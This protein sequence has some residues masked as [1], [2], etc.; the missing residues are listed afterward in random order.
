MLRS[1]TLEPVTVDHSRYLPHSLVPL[2]M[3]AEAGKDIVPSLMKIVEDFGFDGFM[4]AIAKYHLR[5][6]NQEQMSLLSG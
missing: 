6:D 5:P 1:F 3:A 4:F 2:V